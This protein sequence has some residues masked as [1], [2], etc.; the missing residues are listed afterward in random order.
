MVDTIMFGLCHT[1][2]SSG[3]ETELDEFGKP[4]C[5]SCREELAAN[6]RKEENER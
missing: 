3:I 1:C 5:I 6:K 2:K 4:F